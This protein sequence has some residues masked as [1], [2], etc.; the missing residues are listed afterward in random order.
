M[1]RLD[2]TVFKKQS[3]KDSDSQLDYWLSKTPS[4]RI[5]AAIY[6]QSTSYGFDPEHP[7]LMD[8]TLFAK[9]KRD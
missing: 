7:P 6:L 4:E 1:F 5:S 3:F 9:R 2:K 8:K